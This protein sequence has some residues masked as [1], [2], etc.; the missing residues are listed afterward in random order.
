MSK[1]KILICLFG[2]LVFLSSCNSTV[3]NSEDISLSEGEKEETLYEYDEIEENSNVEVEFAS[4]CFNSIDEMIE[5]IQRIKQGKEVDSNNVSTLNSLIVPNFTIDGYYLFKISVTEFS[6][7]Y[8]YTPLSVSRIDGIIDYDRDYV[9]TVRRS[10]YVNEDD[11]LQPLIDQLKIQPDEEGYLYDSINHNII[12]AY[13]NVWVSIRVPA[14]V[15][16]YQ[17]IKSLCTVKSIRLD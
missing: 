10:E 8:Y 6:I 3:E 11:P 16:D 1:I 13:E 12:F 2:I 4:L 7:F 15:K 9:V 5:K 17:E 14:G